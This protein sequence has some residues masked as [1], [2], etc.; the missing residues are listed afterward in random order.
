MT[1]S[2]ERGSGEERRGAC[3]AP[4]GLIH[5]SNSSDIRRSYRFISYRIGHAVTDCFHRLIARREHGKEGVTEPSISMTHSSIGLASSFRP[6]SHPSG[7]HIS[8]TATLRRGRMFLDYSEFLKPYR[9]SAD[10]VLD[11]KI[12]I[13]RIFSKRYRREDR[14]KFST[15]S[16]T[17]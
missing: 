13:K 15:I 9:A 10:A 8:I 12:S 6:R 1:N 11:T 5:P 4:Y 14:P 16:N 2:E 3:I 7:E 17:L